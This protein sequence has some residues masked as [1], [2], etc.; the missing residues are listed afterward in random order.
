LDNVCKCHKNY[1]KS[2]SGDLMECKECPL[3]SNSP[4]NATSINECTC[5][6]GFSQESSTS[7]TCGNCPAGKA[8]INGICTICQKGT[9]R[10]NSAT[11]CIQC[12]KNT[13]SNDQ[14]NTAAAQCIKCT[15]TIA[16]TST[17]GMTGRT[18]VD[19]CH[20]MD[21]RY[22]QYNNQT[23]QQC[24]PCPIGG[25]CKRPNNTLSFYE[26]RTW[27]KPKKWILGNAIYMERS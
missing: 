10:D 24:H 19:D 12:P 26:P 8:D 17:L 22:P 3:N 15:D 4:P 11:T 6:N 9:Y 2:G 16:Y 23:L 14:G 18:T 20:C 21:E 25:T 5:N 13:F 1:Y 7:S 27:M